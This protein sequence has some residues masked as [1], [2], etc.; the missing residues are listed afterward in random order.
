M[1][2]YKFN[3]ADWVLHTSHLSLTEEAIYFRLINHYYDTEQPIPIETQ[4][5]FRRLRMASE[6]DIA[7][8]ILDEFFVKTEKGFIHSRCES[9]LKDYRKTA[10]KNKANGAKGGRP[11][12]DG[13]SSLTQ[14]KPNG[15]P[16]ASQE[17]PKHNPNQELITTNHKP[18]TNINNKAKAKRFAAPEI[19]DVQNYFLD[20]TGDRELS[21]R[22]GIKFHAF[23]ESKGWV[24]GK[25]KMKD[26]KAAVRGWITRMNDKPK[27]AQQQRAESA[28]STFNPDI[29]RQQLEGI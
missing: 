23:Y 9:L 22:E 21:G 4:S 11:K 29:N 5:V 19:I 17:E 26:W 27:T 25:S 10:K 7:V 16:V 13:A 6:S 20:K 14:D 24:V 2:Y 15:L 8:N 1:H 18:L 3:I 28:A 12:K